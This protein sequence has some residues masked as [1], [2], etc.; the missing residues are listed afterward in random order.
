[1][2]RA[3]K[4]TLLVLAILL[5][6]CPMEQSARSQEVQPDQNEMKRL[7]DE[8][9]QLKKQLQEKDEDAQL[10][11]QYIE[12]VTKSLNEVQDNLTQLTQKQSDLSKKYAALVENRQSVSSSQ[13]DDLLSQI[14]SLREQLNRNAT[15]LANTRREADGSKKRVAQLVALVEKLQA[16]IEERTNEIEGLQATIANLRVEMIAKDK[17]IT[18][19]QETI[20]SN[21]RVIE[22]Q[23]RKNAQL[24]NEKNTV[25]YRVDSYANLEADHIIKNT[26]GLLG[27][28]SVWTL[29][30]SDMDKSKFTPK[31]R[32]TVDAIT[33]AA[34]RHRV[35]VISIH[36]PHS[37]ELYPSGRHETILRI[38]NRDAFWGSSPYLVVAVK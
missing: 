17:T 5:L 24:E 11:E 3:L 7:R 25:Y 13:R 10:S 30:T 36:A 2:I 18:D 19:Q 23:G 20:E 28:G 32:Y 35:T 29:G 26:G 37:F 8:N 14:Q 9:E 38:F 1:M 21:N 27:I 22:D 34:P 12:Q 6:G 15:A 4:T 33:I 16:E 31:N